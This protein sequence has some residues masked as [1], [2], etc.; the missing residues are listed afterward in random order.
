MK[1]RHLAVL[2]GLMLLVS[3]TFAQGIIHNETTDGELSDTGPAPTSLGVLGLGLSTI[4]GSL[5]GVS[6]GSGGASNGNDADIFT[7]TVAAGQTVNAITTTR[8]DDNAGFIGYVN[9]ATLPSFTDGPSLG[10]AVESGN[11]FGSG[12]IEDAATGLAPIPTSLGAGD[13]TFILQETVTP[14]DFSISFNVVQAVPEPSSA[15]LLGGLALL[16]CARRRRR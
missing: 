3:P 10:A 12:P 16:G 6:D 7:F 9:A 11:L 13:H 4:E 14:V 1:F 2:L 15:A 5:G 8:T